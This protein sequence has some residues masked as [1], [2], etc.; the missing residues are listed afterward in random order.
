MVIFQS[1]QNSRSFPDETEPAREFVI[2]PE[3]P[4]RED[5]PVDPLFAMSPDGLL[6]VDAAGMIRHANEVAARLLGRKTAKHLVGV[7]FGV[8]VEVG[9]PVLLELPRGMGRFRLA[10]LRVS[11]YDWMSESAYL[12]GLR[13]VTGQVRQREKMKRMNRA[14]SKAQGRET[15]IV[16]V[17]A[18]ESAQ[19][20]GPDSERGGPA[21]AWRRPHPP[22]GRRSGGATGAED[23]ASGGGADGA[24]E[25]GAGSSDPVQAGGGPA[26]AGV[27]VGR[28]GSDW[29]F[30]SRLPAR[31]GFRAPVR[32]GGLRLGGAGG[33]ASAEQRGPLHASGRP[34]SALG[35]PGRERCAVR[36]VDD[37]I[38]IE[39]QSLSTIFRPFVQTKGAREHSSQGLGIGLAIVH[40][41]AEDH[42][43][44]IEVAS[45]GPWRGARSP[46]GFPCAEP[47]T[48]RG[49]ADGGGGAEPCALGGHH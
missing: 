10:E 29:A 46:C 39:S 22:E 5:P 9:V 16:S 13:D 41:V 44:R 45:D 33:G 11:P 40:R 19:S 36:V 7:D 48:P 37:G 21:E 15:R 17:L 12:V 49:P 3:P 31:T 23:V 24:G 43:G 28:G 38:G 27:L 35:E 26:L 2:E 47:G 8:P 18:H 14:L 34:G 6:V 32:G 42:G 4:V 20:S 25:V 1:V 30:E